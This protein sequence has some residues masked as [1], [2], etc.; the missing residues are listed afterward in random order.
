MVYIDSEYRYEKRNS[1]VAIRVELMT[2]N[3]DESI[4]DYQFELIGIDAIFIFSLL[5][6]AF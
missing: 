2:L 1:R 5:R 6:F 3:Y 4:I